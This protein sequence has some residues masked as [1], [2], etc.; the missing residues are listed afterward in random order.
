MDKEDVDLLIKE[1]SG[2]AEKWTQ[3][4]I[5]GL[6]RTFDLEVRNNEREFNLYLNIATISVAFLAIGAPLIRDS[7][8]FYLLWAIISFLLSS[9]IGIVILVI[10]IKRDRR[11]IG[12]DGKYEYSTFRGYLEKNVSIQNKLY[13]YKETSDAELWNTILSEMSEYMNSRK[14]LYGEVEQRKLKKEKEISFIAL[15]YL[16]IAFWCCFISAFMGLAIWLI[17]YIGG[18]KIFLQCIQAFS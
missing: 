11:W 18:D 2:N 3:L 12:D 17:N 5:E 10:T 1:L 9:I 8:S 14:N 6:Y 15:K 13:D 7:L 4:S 16:K